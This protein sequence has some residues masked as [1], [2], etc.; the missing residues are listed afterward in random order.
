MMEEGMMFGDGMDDFNGMEEVL[1][2]H[3]HE[4]FDEMAG[5][6]TKA[7]EAELLGP[8]VAD[9]SLPRV[10]IDTTNMGGFRLSS[11][12]AQVRDRC[13][14]VKT[15]GDDWGSGDGATGSSE[16]DEE[17]E[18]DDEYNEGEE[19]EEEDDI[20]GVGDPREHLMR[21]MAL[22][23]RPVRDM[24][25]GMIPG[26]MGSG[27][28]PPDVLQRLTG[29]LPPGVR[30]HVPGGHSFTTTG[31]AATAPAS[32]AIPLLPGEAQDPRRLLERV[33]SMAH[34]A[35]PQGGDEGGEPDTEAAQPPRR[36]RSTRPRR[37]RVSGGA[38]LH[39]AA[40]SY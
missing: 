32:G 3:V 25:P 14:L 5:A 13:K 29:G 10:T 9:A 1:Q 20:W 16:E 15:R 30:M 40:Y 24:I 4:L 8:S 37:G 17:D 39:E 2:E 28:P 23:G 11:L 35:P 21:M 31:D 36:N 22:A 12:E 27:G 38:E 6:P 33:M 7:A 34:R 18:E 19:G 26:R